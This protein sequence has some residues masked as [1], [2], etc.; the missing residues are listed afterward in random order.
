MN[1]FDPST[2]MI[3]GLIV[4]VVIPLL[5]ALLTRAHWPTEVVGLLTV[6]LAT[7]NGF[8]TEWANAGD[9]FRWQV[10]LSTAIVSYVLAVA[11]HYGIWKGTSTEARAL[12]APAAKTKPAAPPVAP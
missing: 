8:F 1:F 7:A 3:V 6:L 9:R 10:A 11:A 12:A 5:S 2:A 4:S